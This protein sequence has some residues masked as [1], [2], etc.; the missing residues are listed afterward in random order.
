MKVRCTFKHPD[1]LYSAAKNVGLEF[2]TPEH[3]A[4]EELAYKFIEYGEY[5]TVEFDT[6][7]G[8]CVVIPRS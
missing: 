8:T 7:A 5:L 6:E 4:F 3:E 1:A 2:D